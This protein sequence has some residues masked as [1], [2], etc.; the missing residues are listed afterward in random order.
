MP[1]P[2][3]EGDMNYKRYQNCIS[4][5]KHM[6]MCNMRSYYMYKYKEQ[7]EVI[8]HVQHEVILHVQH[9]VILHEQI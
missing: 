2:E 4:T 5:L 1:P 9:E 7:H 8:L 3:G 6:K